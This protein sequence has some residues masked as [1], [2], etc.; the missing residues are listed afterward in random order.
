MQKFTT[1]KFY[2]IHVRKVS[3]VIWLFY[4]FAHVQLIVVHVSTVA[5][6]KIR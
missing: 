2:G 5:Q 4:V 3:L 6:I 1:Q